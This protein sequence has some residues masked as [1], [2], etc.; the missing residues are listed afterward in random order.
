VRCFTAILRID[1]WFAVV[2]Q[3]CF[4]K[5]SVLIVQQRAAQDELR[6]LTIYRVIEKDGWDL[7][8]L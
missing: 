2:P 4:V 3:E 7:K 6:L 8:P 5:N 1:V